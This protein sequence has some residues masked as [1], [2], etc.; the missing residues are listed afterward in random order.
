MNLRSLQIQLLLLVSV[1]AFWL[2]LP[3]GS[4]FAHSSFSFSFSVALSLRI[5]GFHRQSL[6]SPS[7]SLRHSHALPARPYSQFLPPFPLRRWFFL[8][9]F[10]PFFFFK[11][12]IFVFSELFLVVISVLKIESYSPVEKVKEAYDKLE[13]EWYLT[14]VLLDLVTQRNGAIVASSVWQCYC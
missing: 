14:F 5:S 10:L 11:F 1:S 4:G 7:H 2:L 8:P 3:H 12:W 13:S 6:R 9:S